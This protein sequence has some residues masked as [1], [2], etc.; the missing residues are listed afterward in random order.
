MTTT[1]EEAMIQKELHP[2][3]SKNIFLWKLHFSSRKKW[4]NASR[5]FCILC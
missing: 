4:K 2:G 1:K 5:K 3:F